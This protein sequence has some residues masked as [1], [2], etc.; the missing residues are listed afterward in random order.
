MRILDYEG[1]VAERHIL[2]R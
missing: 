2:K 1:I